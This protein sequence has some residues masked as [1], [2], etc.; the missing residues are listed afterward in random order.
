LQRLLCHADISTTKE[1]LNLI[2]DDLQQDYDTFNPHEQMTRHQGMLTM[3]KMSWGASEMNE[4]Q[5]QSY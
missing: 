5:G 1:Y 3:K 2:I 4:E